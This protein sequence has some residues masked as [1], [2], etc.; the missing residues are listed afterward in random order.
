MSGIVGWSPGNQSAGPKPSAIC[1]RV[2]LSV[3]PGICLTDVSGAAVGAPG[4]VATGMAYAH[5]GGSPSARSTAVAARD[6][7][8]TTTKACN[9]RISSLPMT[10]RLLLIVHG[11]GGD[12]L[13]R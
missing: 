4:G 8:T 7:T 12:L 1:C 10:S 2:K 13:A 9:L 6:A 3:L 11:D 5:S